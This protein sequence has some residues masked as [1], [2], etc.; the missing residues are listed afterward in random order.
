MVKKFAI[1]LLLGLFNAA[2]V[3]AA[4]M[5]EIDRF[6]KIITIG[7]VIECSADLKVKYNKEK[8]NI[9]M[10]TVSKSLRIADKNAL[11]NSVTY[12]SLQ[13]QRVPYMRI[14]FDMAL[15]NEGEGQWAKIEPDSVKVL[16]FSDPKIEKQTA[17]EIRKMSPRYT[18]WKDVTFTHFPD[19][20]VKMKSPT[21]ETGEIIQ[22]CHLLNKK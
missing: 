1:F 8:Y 18:P 10:R 11:Y 2:G 3:N 19:Y 12:Y 5:S 20:M 17:D 4:S 9:A 16:Y 21:V 13:G 7:D 14:D 15:T 22:Y 6:K